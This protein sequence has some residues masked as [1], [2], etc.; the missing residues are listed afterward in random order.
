[1]DNLICVFMHIANYR[2]WLK[3]G[4][5]YK[6]PNSTLLKLKAAT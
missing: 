3:K 1:M 4:S 5:T 6:G 2:S